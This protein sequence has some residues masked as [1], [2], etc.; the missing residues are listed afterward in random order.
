MQ[1]NNR[2]LEK[3]QSFIIFLQESNPSN[4]TDSLVKI[5][6]ILRKDADI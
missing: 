1:I 6:D 5:A 3:L 4:F 2:M